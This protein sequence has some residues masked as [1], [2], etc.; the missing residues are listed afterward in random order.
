M[1]NSVVIATI[2]SFTNHRLGRPPWCAGV[3]ESRSR[4]WR[5]KSRHSVCAVGAFDV[6]SDGTLEVITGWSSGRV[7]AVPFV[8]FRAWHFCS[9]FTC[10]SAVRRLHSARPWTGRCST[11]TR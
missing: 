2:T 5:V 1:F 8:L 11:G 9:L 3:Y 10:A 6:D 7:R 4:R